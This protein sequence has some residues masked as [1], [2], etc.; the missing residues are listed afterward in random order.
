[1]T[2]CEQLYS[3]SV[4]VDNTDAEGRLI[5][6]DALTYMARTHNPANMV[7]VATL[8][9]AIHVALGDRLTGCFATH[10]ELWELIKKAG[11]E[12]GQGMWRMPLMRHF[13]QPMKSDVADLINSGS[14]RGG[15]SCTAAAFLQEFTDE[16]P[17]WA[18]LDIAG[19]M[20][21]KADSG[22][23]AK[24]MTGQPTRSLYRLVKRAAAAH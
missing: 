20:Q 5:L 17:R 2:D 10:D 1:M 9:G 21:A 18:H 19:V 16:H 6:A 22:V 14:G 13:L 24:G 4:Q 3:H 15:G 11:E 12:A 23:L 7:D 8:T